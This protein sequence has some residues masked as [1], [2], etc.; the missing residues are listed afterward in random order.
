MKKI[1]GLIDRTCYLPFFDYRIEL[2]HFTTSL[3]STGRRS[4]S[5]S[6]VVLVLVAEANSEVIV[7]AKLTFVPHNFSLEV[8][9]PR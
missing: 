5:H 1:T 4:I 8:N 2:S 9:E 3:G 6:D 7:P